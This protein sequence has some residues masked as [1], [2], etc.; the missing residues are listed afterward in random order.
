MGAGVL[1]FYRRPAM[2]ARVAVRRFTAIRRYAG[3]AVLLA[4]GLC[5]GRCW[6]WRYCGDAGGGLCRIMPAQRQRLFSDLCRASAWI[7]LLFSHWTALPH[8]TVHWFGAV[9]GIKSHHHPILN[10]R[11]VY[12]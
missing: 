3:V 1:V 6:W 5:G 10:S 11:N 12:R 8:E 2:L 9:V 4:A 7:W